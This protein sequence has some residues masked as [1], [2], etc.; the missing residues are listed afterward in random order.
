MSLETSKIDAALVALEGEGFALRGHF[1]PGAVGDEFC[2]RG[3]LARIHRGTLHR[4]RQEIAPVTAAEFIR[5]LLD[6]HQIT[7]DPRPQGPEALARALAQLEGVSAPAAA[8][9]DELLPARLRYQ[10]ADLDALALAGAVVWARLGAGPGRRA[11]VR[12]TPVALLPRDHAAAW[13]HLSPRTPDLADLSPGA[14][15]LLGLLARRGALFF[16]ELVAHSRLLRAQ[17]E[18]ALGELVARGLCTSDGFAGLRALIGPGARRPRPGAR[19]PRPGFAPMDRAGR[20]SLVPALDPAALA[21]LTG[22]AAPDAPDLLTPDP[23][24]DLD[25]DPDALEHLARALL[26][27][28]GVVFRGLLARERGLPPW[29]DLVRV[30]RRLEARGELR[31]GHFVA[32]AAAGGEHFALPEAV[33][34]LR[35]QRR[36]PPGD[37]LV[38]VAAADPLCLVGV[39]TPGERL[40][41]LLGNRL[42]YR[43]GVP[44]AVLDAGHVRHLAPPDPADA[45]W[46][47]R[48]LTRGVGVHPRDADAPISGV[49]RALS[50][51]S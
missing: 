33:G 22:D 20:W 41:A 49:R 44:V 17:A 25:L 38:C 50:D 36:R 13:S 19:P 14:R 32:S 47:A 27:R 7:A 39:L 46:I 35:D 45:A 21:A 9:E 23:A 37:A 3:L 26:R 1:T 42:L 6:W 34:L 2:E 4:L 48:A 40:P 11:P 10:G 31:G 5:F 30:Y 28:Y 12:S 15:A 8:W 24:P 16:A 18:D 43:D 51:R 29:R